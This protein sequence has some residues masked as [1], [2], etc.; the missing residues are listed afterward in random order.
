L[1]V[2]PDATGDAAVAEPAPPIARR[3]R[4]DALRSVVGASKPRFLKSFG[5][6][7]ITGASD[8]DP[9]GIGTYSQAG[10]QFGFSLSW[11]MLLTYPLMVGIQEISARVGRVTGR[12]I[13]GNLCRHYPNWVLQAVV[14]ALFIA[15]TINIAADLAAMADAVTLLIGGPQ[16]L[17]VVA[18]GVVAIMAQIFVQYARYVRV[19]KWLT[20]SLLSYVAALA[21]VHVP[22]GDALSGL[23]LPKLT[24]SADY[25]MMLVAIAGTTISPYLFFWQAS[26][27]AE[28]VRV[29]PHRSPLRWA[30]RQA[31]GALARIRTDTIVGMAVSNL[32][33]VAIMMTSAA[34]LNAHGVTDVET[35]AQAA[36]ALRPI[37]GKFAALVFALG[38]IGTGLLGVPVLAGSAA[39]AVGEARRWPVGLGREP[40]EAVA[41]YATLGIAIMIGIGL[42]FASID[43]IK[44]LYW[45]AVVNGVMA[46]PVM[47][48]LMS[49]AARPRVMGEFAVRGRLSLLGWLSTIAMAG[50]IAGMVASWFI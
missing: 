46:A 22:W 38:I 39:Y 24:W 33:A 40:R 30:P 49:M 31:R 37:A 44:A 16:L 13:A 12:G 4:L 10:A 14:A 5:P 48:L 23:F 20:L 8:D 29:K 47:A 1:P 36:E 6:G 17:F 34:S 41:F 2:R 35:S 43:P 32:I 25:F 27:E 42:N 7:L 45:S 28:D 11:T 19:L 3:G 9:S 21:A 18:F 26:Q 15:N 50:C